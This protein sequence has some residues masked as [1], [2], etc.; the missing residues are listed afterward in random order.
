MKNKALMF[1]GL[2]FTSMSV[3]SIDKSFFLSTTI[4]INNIYAD[5][6]TNVEFEP[7]S[8]TLELNSDNS[9]FETTSAI[10]K[11]SS[12]IPSEASSVS[13]TSTM[14]QNTSTCSGSFNNE[15]V[16]QNEFVR[17]T[18]D[19]NPVAIN[20]PVIIEDFNSNDGTFKTSEHELTLEFKS[21][22]EIDMYGSP[23]ECQGN[24][25]FSIGV[26]I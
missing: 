5:S 15:D 25:I 18:L 20:V 23:E 24:V 1:L 21:F 12:T 4:D 22:S 7:A 13:Y 3:H 19:E 11:I 2:T 8:L 16:P 26:D 10:M 6:I 9:G 14:I 17:V